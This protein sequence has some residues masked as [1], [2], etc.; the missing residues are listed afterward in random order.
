[1]ASPIKSRTNEQVSHG[2]PFRLALRQASQFFRWLYTARIL[3]E[4]FSEGLNI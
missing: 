2:L 1:M 3:P 4:I